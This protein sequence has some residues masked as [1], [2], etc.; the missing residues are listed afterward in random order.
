MGLG[1]GIYIGTIYDCKPTIRFI[2]ECL[3]RV[4]PEEAIPIKKN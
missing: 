4:I 2:V 1:A 3:K